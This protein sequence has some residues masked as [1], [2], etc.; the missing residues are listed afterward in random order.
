MGAKV[1]GCSGHCIA[2]MVQCKLAN[3]GNW[4][5]IFK[6]CADFIGCA[7]GG[8]AGGSGGGGG[9]PPG[10]SYASE[11]SP[12]EAI[13][14]LLVAEKTA[15]GLDGQCIDLNRECNRAA[16]NPIQRIQ[17]MVQLGVCMGAKVA[18][19]SGHCIP[20]MITCKLANI[21]NWG[22]IFGCCAQFIAC[23]I[24]GCA[25]GG[26]GGGGGGPPP[27]LSYAGKTTPEEAAVQLV[28]A[29]KSAYGLD[30]QCISLNQECNR[31]ATNP[32][33]R[34]QCMI[35]LGLCMGAKVVGCSGHCIAPMV[36]CK[37]ANIGNWGGIFKCCA[38]FI[39]CAVGGC[40]GGSGGGGGGGGPPGL[41]Y[42]ETEMAL[43][44]ISAAVDVFYSD[45]STYG[46]FD[47]TCRTMH[48][49][50]D[51]AAQNFIQKMQCLAQLGMCL[52]AKVAGCSGHCIPP[53]IQCKMSAFGNWGAM[54]KCCADF[55]GCAIGGCASGGGGGGGGG[56]GPPEGIMFKMDPD[57]YSPYEM[58][59]AT[60]YNDT[61]FAYTIN[62]QQCQSNHQSCVASAGRDIRKKVDCFIKFGMCIGLQAAGCSAL[63]VP[64]L[65]ICSA[66]NFG[67]WPGLF[68]CATKFV[69]C[70]KNSCLGAGI[71]G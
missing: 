59:I 17:C 16:T 21:G 5:G 1:V 32:L 2:P 58:A 25:G 8:C 64:E 38:D 44:P 70:A 19:C 42:K 27:G 43:S 67:N 26:G 53:L 65:G 50:C 15:Y 18:G 10:L 14:K 37:L 66:M 29:E 12:E 41:T 47:D 62:F 20:T 36:Q 4:G 3:I 11:V 40:A 55:I 60:A 68:V 45:K 39:G 7:V 33:Q 23:A 52:G 35:Q 34:I 22:G 49:E 61:N 51:R 69:F 30:G 28:L 71:L 63:C 56:G 13:V 31:A 57:D 6:C 54:F 46:L 24:G 48:E 9:G